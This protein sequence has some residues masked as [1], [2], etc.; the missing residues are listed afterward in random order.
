MR[1]NEQNKETVGKWE[2]TKVEKKG[3]QAGKQGRHTKIN[4]HIRQ[5]TVTDLQ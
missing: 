1:E 3:I 4:R 2:Q 5:I